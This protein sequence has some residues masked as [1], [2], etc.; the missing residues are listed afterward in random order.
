MKPAR[1]AWTV[2][3]LAALVVTTACGTGSDSGGLSDAAESDTNAQGGKKLTPLKMVETPGGP[4]SFISYG[5]SK[6]CFADE[7][8][9][10]TVEPN[11]GGGT[12]VVPQV[13]SG[14]F[15]VAGLDLVSALTTMSRGLPLKMVAAGSSTSSEPAGD[16][17]GLLVKPDSP[18]KGP[19]DLEGTTIGVNALRNINEIAIRD[20][21]EKEGI[22]RN[23]VKLVE[24]PFPEILAAV[25]RGDVDA[26]LEIEPFV[27]IGEAQGMRVVHRPWVGVKPDL[28][29]GTMVMTEEKIAEDPKLVD[30]FAAAV[31]CTA[32]AV[33]EDPDAFRTALPKLVPELKAPIAQQMNLIQWQGESDLGSIELTGERLLKY[34][35]IEKRVDYDAVTLH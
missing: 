29:I 25:Q 31:E 35:L 14:E 2:L 30:S 22:P 18:I 21:L 17:S 7:G 23:K 28:Q 26:G 33:A 9:D 11:A 34:G 19:E 24:M 12:S 4:I 3:T 10:L 15:D 6:D 8:I 16:F 13:L 27:T 5:I 32:D 1:T 20:A